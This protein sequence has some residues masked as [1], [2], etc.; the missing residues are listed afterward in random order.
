MPKT[1]SAIVNISAKF[2][3]ASAMYGTC[4]PNRNSRR[5]TG[6]TYRLVIDPSSFSRTMASAI[7]IA[8]NSARSSA[9][10][11]GTIA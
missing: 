8:G 6:V 4:L 11:D 9:M 1:N 2:S 5:L 3:I 7:R 10:V